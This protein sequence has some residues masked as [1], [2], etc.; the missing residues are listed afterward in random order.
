[1]AI[2]LMTRTRACSDLGALLPPFFFS[3]TSP[4]CSSHRRALLDAPGIPFLPHP[5]LTLSQPLSML[6]FFTHTVCLSISFLTLSHS[7]LFPHNF[8]FYFWSFFIFSFTITLPDNVHV[9]SLPSTT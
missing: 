1:M 7:F 3:F 4:T 6:S 9:S 5:S 2:Q 8:H